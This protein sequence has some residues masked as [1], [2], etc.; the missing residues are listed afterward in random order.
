[1]R[2][3]PKEAELP[4]AQHRSVTGE[5][6]EPV[7]GA[8]DVK[9][10]RNPHPIQRAVD[11]AIGNVEVSVPIDVDETQPPNTISKAGNG[12]DTNRAVTAENQNRVLGCS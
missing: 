8:V 9:H 4:G 1:M 5:R 7:D 11:R 3:E 2:P 12:A 6:R 10:V